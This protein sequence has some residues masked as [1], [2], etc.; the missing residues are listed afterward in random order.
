[1][2]AREGGGGGAAAVLCERGGAEAGGAAVRGAAGLGRGIAA[3]AVE[4]S[5]G[6]LSEVEVRVGERDAASANLSLLVSLY[7][8][9]APCCVAE[10]A[11]PLQAPPQAR[12][13]PRH[14]PTSR[15]LSP[16][17]LISS[18]GHVGQGGSLRRQLQGAHALSALSRVP[19][20]TLSPPA[21][22]HGL[23]SASLSPLL[24][25][26][27]LPRLRLALPLEPELTHFP[28]T[29]EN[30][31]PEGVRGH[32]EGKGASSASLPPSPPSSLDPAQ[33]LV[34]WLTRLHLLQDEE[35]VEHAKAAEAAAAQGAS[36]SHAS[37]ARR[38]PS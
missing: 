3:S 26:P 14:R 7:L 9:L 21:E 38:P 28:A 1:V 29:A 34:P 36:A 24:L 2:T 15:P 13:H 17:V 6:H 25:D 19:S 16:L 4:L 12:P 10:H 31:G 27:S 11:R 20:L 33:P 30:M 37:P 22:R 18:P 35:I 8:C 32:C 23:P 5:G